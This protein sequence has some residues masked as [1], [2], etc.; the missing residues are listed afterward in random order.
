MTTPSAPSAGDGPDDSAKVDLSKHGPGDADPPFDPYRFGRPEHPVPP[1][2]APPG[3]IPDPPAEPPANPY[4][5]ANPYGPPPGQYGA[6]P[7]PYGSQH[8]AQPYHP[9]GPPPGQQPY[10]GY[11]Y[12]YG[13]A[14][15]GTNGK[16]L[17]AMIL[18]IA[19]IPLFFLTFLD[20]ALIVPALVFGILGLRESTRRNGKGRG[21]AIAGLACMVVG[22]IG[23]TVFAV[24]VFGRVG[25]CEHYLRDG[26]NTGYHQCVNDRFN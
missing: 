13:A 12:G 20:L 3:Y 26:D 7:N 2:F 14:P 1:E 24:W 18:G 17:T 11:G 9:Y 15:T 4:G 25:D 21:Q 22:A 16:A 6:P 10:P 19:S 5:T 8:Q 23:A